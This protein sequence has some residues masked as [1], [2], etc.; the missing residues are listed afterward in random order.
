MEKTTMVLT[1]D[2]LQKFINDQPNPAV[3][4]ALNTVFQKYTEAPKKGDTHQQ[5]TLKEFD[6]DET[7]K[8]IVT[9]Y[10]DKKGYSKD[11]AHVVAMAEVKRQ[12]EARNLK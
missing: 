10:I 6:R 3:I 9:F 5:T 7:Y 8:K 2:W 1:K 12:V 11:A 4:L